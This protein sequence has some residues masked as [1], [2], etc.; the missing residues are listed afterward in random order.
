MRNDLNEFFFGV[1]KS[2]HPNMGVAK[3]IFGG[4]W[5]AKIFFSSIY[6][7]AQI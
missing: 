6:F 4:Y 7:R 2:G 1:F 5:G 3:S